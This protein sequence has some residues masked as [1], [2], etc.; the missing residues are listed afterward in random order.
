[1]EGIE[2]IIT[3]LENKETDIL[4]SIDEA[5]IQISELELRRH[6][7]KGRMYEV[8]NIREAIDELQRG[9]EHE[10]D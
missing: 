10:T 8:L 1:M 7:L 3:I 9:T 4:T 2:D 5:D 6:Y